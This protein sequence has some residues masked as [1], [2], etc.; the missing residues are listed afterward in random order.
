MK[1]E[2]SLSSRLI[3]ENYYQNNNKSARIAAEKTLLAFKK[4]GVT[5][6]ETALNF[7]P[8]TGEYFLTEAAV[9]EI[10]LKS[11]NKK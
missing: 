10:I 3:F 7:D 9:V 4:M 2:N 6:L 11:A 8:E 1:K 5:T